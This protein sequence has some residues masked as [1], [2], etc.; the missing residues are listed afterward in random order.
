LKLHADE[1]LH[2]K[3]ADL[4][5][6]SD[7][8]QE[9][10]I[11]SRYLLVDFQRNLINKDTINYFK[12]LLDFQN[13]S[14]QREKLFNGELINYTEKKSALHTFCRSTSTRKNI[15]PAIYTEIQ[16]I[17]N[18]I[19][20]FRKKLVNGEITSNL[21][22]KINSIVSIGI[23]GSH[24]GLQLTIN[25]LKEFKVS[26]SPEIHLISTPD[27]RHV[28][29]I[30]EKIEI[31]STLFIL[32]SKSFTTQETFAVADWILDNYFSESSKKDVIKSQFLALTSQIDA[33]L[34]YGIQP[35]YI[36]KVLDGVGGRYSIWS[37]SGLPLYIL[38]GE[39]NYD[40]FLKGAEDMDNHFLSREI[41]K[42]IPVL[43]ALLSFWYTN[44]FNSSSQ[45]I[46]PYFFRLRYF[47][48][49]LQQLEMESNGKSID[50]QNNQIQHKSSPAIWGGVGTNTQ[51]SFMQL[52]HQGTLLIPVDFIAVREKNE[53]NIFDEI[54]SANLF[55][56][57]DCLAYGNQTDKH[58]EISAEKIISGNKP[59]TTIILKKWSPESLGSLI[60]LYEHKV[61]TMGILSGIN[62]FD[63]F[64]VETG[65]KIAKDIYS[66]FS[67][68]KNNLNLSLK[69]SIDKYLEL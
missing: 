62:S 51:H 36:F 17:K 31:N 10:A 33:A 1:A 3:L 22:N 25:A 61:F 27:K 35:D 52:L 53:K 57:S 50:R 15:D 60:A 32:S 18:K 7:R 66:Y 44:F 9:Y 49:Y 59:S 45:A 63:Q 67:H 34:S 6:N 37:A 23:G 12:K 43:M 47:P 41:E 5:E 58:K 14:A 40:L 4:L 13:F 65:K 11:D 21:G 26:D 38:I 54:L 8:F 64:G 20:L 29:D 48:E 69:K 46:I 2:W 19:R 68:K 42:N 30:M 56:Q 16:S 24:L 39:T 28:Q 55:A